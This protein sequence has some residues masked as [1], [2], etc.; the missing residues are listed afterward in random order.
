MLKKFNEYVDNSSMLI[1]ELNSIEMKYP[2]ISE[3]FFIHNDEQ[4][5]KIIKYGEKILPYI[6]EKLNDKYFMYCL[7]HLNK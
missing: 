1:E 3:L 5:L 2:N 6:K 7:M 4:Y